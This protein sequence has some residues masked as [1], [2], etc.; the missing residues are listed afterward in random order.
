MP[1]TIIIVSDA[2]W[3]TYSL[4]E[5]HI[6]YRGKLWQGGNLANHINIAVGKIKFGESYHDMCPLCLI[7][8][9]VLE[10]QLSSLDAVSFTSHL[11]SQGV[12]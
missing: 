2:L 12:H 5:F 10:R 3:S 9:N 7:S 11:D 4:Q 8:F 6:A 1:L